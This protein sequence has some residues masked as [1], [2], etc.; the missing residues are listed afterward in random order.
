MDIHQILSSCNSKSEF[1]K[2]IIDKNKFNKRIE[3]IDNMVIGLWSSLPKEAGNLMKER[4]RLSELLEKVD[5]LFDQSKFY[6]ELLIELPEEL[7]V[8]K[9]MILYNEIVNL[10]QKILFSNNDDNRSAILTI[11]AG[12]G[13]LEAANWVSMLSRMYLRW[14]N[15]NNLTVECLYKNDS[16]EHS[17]IC[18]DSISIK[19]DGIH[20]YGLLKSETGVHRLIR[21]SPFNSGDARHTSFAAVSVMPDIEN[22]I[23][24]KIEDKDLEIIA[25]T[26]SGSGGQ[27]VNKVASAIRLKHIPTGI[28]ILVRTQR[29][30]LSNKKTAFKLLKAKL[31]MLELKKKQAEKD[32]ILNS[33]MNINFGSQIRTYTLTPYSLVKDH[34]TDFEINNTDKVLDGDINGFI[35]SFLR[36]SVYIL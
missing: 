16:E 34:R 29:D 5:S 14:A 3:E 13:G 17:D 2:S 21:N 11:N 10:E 23:D 7:D 15:N 18:T 8:D 30:Q 35:D 12:A 33:Q 24:I 36:K 26:S 22:T 1:L 20:A 27:N 19:F 6:N 32:K 31:Y 4:Q 28:N 9:S 25:Q